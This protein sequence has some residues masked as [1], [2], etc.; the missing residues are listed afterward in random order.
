MNKYAQKVYL[1][2]LCAKGFKEQEPA[3]THAMWY[4]LFYFLIP[5][6]GFMLFINAVNRRYW[7]YRYT[8]MVLYGTSHPEIYKGFGDE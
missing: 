5:I 7:K 4:H 2:L 1:D 3:Y 8:N 6:V